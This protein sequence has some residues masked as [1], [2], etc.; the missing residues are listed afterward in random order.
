MKVPVTTK[1]Y[2]KTE[3]FLLIKKFLTR[4][5]LQTI[6]HWLVEIVDNNV[7]CTIWERIC[8]T[9]GFC[10]LSILSRKHLKNYYSELGIL[11]TSNSNKGLFFFPFLMLSLILCNAFLCKCFTCQ[12]SRYVYSCNAINSFQCAD[13]F[14]QEKKWVFL[15]KYV[16]L[17]L[18]YW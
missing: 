10:K 8:I 17:I 1:V 5:P 4:R 2:S 7:E 12:I 15:H 6:T 11:Q 13:E 18:L 3:Y 14:K 9:S 16:K